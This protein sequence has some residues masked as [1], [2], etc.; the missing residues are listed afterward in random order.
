[1]F[2]IFQLHQSNEVLKASLILIHMTTFILQSW[3]LEWQEKVS[4]T[5]SRVYFQHR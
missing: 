4:V 2:E 5:C 3:N 1:M